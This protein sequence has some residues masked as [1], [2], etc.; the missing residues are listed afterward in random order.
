MK[1][2]ILDEAEEDLARG[3]AFYEQQQPG[4]GQYFLNALSSDIDLLQR[5][6]GLHAEYFG[7]LRL[8]SRR[9]PYAVYYRVHGDAVRVYAILDCRQSPGVI[10]GRLGDA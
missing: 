6:S 10:V 7:F 8:L 3:F 9:F 1:I 2:E 4:L 5:Y